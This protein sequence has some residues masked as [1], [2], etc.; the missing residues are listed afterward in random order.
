MASYNFFQC[1][2]CLLNLQPNENGNVRG[3]ESA[4][5]GNPILY[6]D[7]YTSIDPFK[8]LKSTD[9]GTVVFRGALFL[10]GKDDLVMSGQ[11]VHSKDGNHS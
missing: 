3:R 2:C 1:K 11:N 5:N 7:R 10:I 6:A 9:I 8:H 4:T